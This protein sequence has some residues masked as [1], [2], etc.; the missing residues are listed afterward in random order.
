MGDTWIGI[1]NAMVSSKM[2]A[3]ESLTDKPQN[4]TTQQLLA[5]PAWLRKSYEGFSLTAIEI[6]LGTP[7]VAMLVANP[8][9]EQ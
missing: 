3:E 2:I 9:I 1:K 7:L 6:S 5:A 8:L 4:S